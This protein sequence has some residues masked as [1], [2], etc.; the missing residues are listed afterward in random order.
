MLGGKISKKY[1]LDGLAEDTIKLQ[2][3]GT[4]GNSFAALLPKGVTFNV[5]GDANDYFGKGLSGGKLTIAPQANTTF[6]PEENIVIGNVA[7][8]GA[9]SGEAYIRGMAGERFA[10]RN[11]GATA[12]VE[13]VGDF[14]GGDDRTNWVSVANG[15]AEN[16]NVRHGV[17]FLK[18]VKVCADAP[19]TRLNFVRD[20]QSAACTNV[21]I[22]CCQIALWE[23]NL[24]ADAGAGFCD[25]A[26]DPFALSG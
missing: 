17:L 12:V 18:G 26:C 19:V 7:L 25:V 8:Y 21:P 14:A 9:T 23:N 24:P 22:R 2:L 6:V 1:G 16:Y 10:V 4:G 13:G 5:A 15:L 3:D 20:A 11:S